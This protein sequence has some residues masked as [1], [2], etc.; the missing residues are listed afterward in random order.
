VLKSLHTLISIQQDQQT[1]PNKPKLESSST[2]WIQI[3]WGWKFFWLKIAWRDR[4][5]FFLFW[6]WSLCLGMW[7]NNNMNVGARFV[8]K[9]KE[10]PQINNYFMN[11]YVFFIFNYIISFQLIT[12]MDNLKK[13][14]TKLYIQACATSA[15]G[16]D[17]GRLWVGSVSESSIRN[18]PRLRIQGPISPKW[19]NGYGGSRLIGFSGCY[20]WVMS[21]GANIGPVTDFWPITVFQIFLTI[22]WTSSEFY[23]P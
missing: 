17:N 23:P 13:W 2:T 21:D 4:Q 15:L 5:F 20:G 10:N 7:R 6:I 19:S 18:N 14:K 12:R 22:N 8:K 11:F 3:A 1:E 16:V 9:F